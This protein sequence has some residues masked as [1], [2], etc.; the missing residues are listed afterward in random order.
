MVL[1]QSSRPGPASAGSSVRI[2][3]SA[4]RIVGIAGAVALNAALFMLLLAPM[5]SGLVLPA[6]APDLVAVHVLAP[7]EPPP[8]PPPVEAEVSAPRPQPVPVQARQ[9]QE[10][11]EPAPVV[12]EPTGALD[13]PVVAPADPGPPAVAPAPAGPVAG[14]RLQYAS[15][16]PPPYPRR[17]L[18]DRVEGQVLLRVLVD[19]DGRPLDVV[20]ERSSGNRNLDRAAQQHI[21]RH[22]TFHPAMQDGRAVQAVGLVPISYKLQ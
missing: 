13:L 14:V 12:V 21:L 15:A 16:P 5:G 4:A 20:V 18:A 8:P 19:V 17:E 10:P 7:P 9:A 11:A 2:H 3:P 1:V 6:P 22:W